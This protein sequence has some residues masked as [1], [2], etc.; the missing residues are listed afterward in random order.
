MIGNLEQY[1]AQ[2]CWDFRDEIAR[3]FPRVSI[4]HGLYGS[5][6]VHVWDLKAFHAIFIKEQ[7]AYEEPVQ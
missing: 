5:K 2:Q 7:D 1:L 4:L 6:W 3:T